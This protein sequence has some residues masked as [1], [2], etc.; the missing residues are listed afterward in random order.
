MG[1]LPFEKAA[2]LFLVRN[3]DS[4]LPMCEITFIPWM[5]FQS[6][7]WIFEM[8]KEENDGI[9]EICMERGNRNVVDIP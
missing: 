5:L 2:F 3:K 9:L 1:R 4:T 6:E 7:S 8:E